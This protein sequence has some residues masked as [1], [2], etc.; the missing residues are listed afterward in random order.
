MV[1]PVLAVIALMPQT[2]PAW[3]STL[4]AVGASVAGVYVKALLEAAF[5]S[6]RWAGLKLPPV[7][8]EGK[9]PLLGHITKIIGQEKFLQDCRDSYGPVF[10]LDLP[11]LSRHPVPV[12]YGAQEVHE[13]LGSENDLVVSSWPPG[14]VELLGS[15][16]LTAV[17]GEKHRRLRQV[18]PP[19]RILELTAR[20]P[21]KELPPR[22]SLDI[23]IFGAS[24]L[25]VALSARYSTGS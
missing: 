11:L 22:I 10:S 1:A 6:H 3:F 13:L 21:Q 23:I 19:S 17:R 16:T 2:T 20:W 18:M 15:T 8:K 25:L 24:S 12:V 5:W 9:Q 7:V 4:C 14:V